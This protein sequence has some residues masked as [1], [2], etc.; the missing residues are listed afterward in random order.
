MEAAERSLRERAV[1]RGRLWQVRHGPGQPG[2]LLVHCGRR[3]HHA[4]SENVRQSGARRPELRAQLPRH[5]PLPL[6]A[7]RRMG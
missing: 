6:L 7:L 3:G 1:R 5:L 2:Q 4:E